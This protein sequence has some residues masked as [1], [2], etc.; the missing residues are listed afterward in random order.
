ME[1]IHDEKMQMQSLH[2]HTC[3]QLRRWAERLR[4]WAIL[5]VRPELLLL[6]RGKDV[7]LRCNVR[8]VCRR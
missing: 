4:L 1:I 5:Q 6:K 8:P 3:L 2:L 7:V